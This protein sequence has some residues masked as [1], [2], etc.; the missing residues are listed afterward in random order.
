[1]E[2]PKRNVDESAV[3]PIEKAVTKPKG[4]NWT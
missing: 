3:E 4:G 2:R 1:M